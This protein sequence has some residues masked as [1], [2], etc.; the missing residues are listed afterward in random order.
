MNEFDNFTVAGHQCVTYFDHIQRGWA[1]RCGSLG[2]QTLCD[3][4]E[5]AAKKLTKAVNDAIA[6]LSP[7]QQK[8]AMPEEVPFEH[9]DSELKQ[10][11][12]DLA[13][14]KEAQV[15]KNLAAEAKKLHATTTIQQD[16]QSVITRIRAERPDRVKVASLLDKCIDML[17]S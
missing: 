12:T 15:E 10:H 14:E 16:L 1:A 11:A 4:Q 5:C 6:R 7:S 2:I 9:V 13:V 17:H 3:N 8:N